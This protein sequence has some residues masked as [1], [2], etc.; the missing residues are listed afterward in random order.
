MNRV[1]HRLVNGLRKATEALDRATTPD[2]IRRALAH[3]RMYEDALITLE[4]RE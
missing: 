1:L 4:E 3:K 2:E